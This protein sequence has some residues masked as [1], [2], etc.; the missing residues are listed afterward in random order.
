MT[1]RHCARSPA[2]PLIWPTAVGYG[3]QG[4]G[5]SPSNCPGGAQPAVRTS[6]NPFVERGRARALAEQPGVAALPELRY[7]AER[8]PATQDHVCPVRPALEQRRLRGCHG[9]D[10]DERHRY[11]DESTG[12]G[13][14]G[15]EPGV[16][17]RDQ[18]SC[19]ACVIVGTGPGVG[20]AATSGTDATTFLA[21]RFLDAVAPGQLV[22]APNH[23]A[24]T[25][26][27]QLGTTMNFGAPPP[28]Y[29]VRRTRAGASSRTT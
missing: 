26:P 4:S 18:D 28:A 12:P 6:R 11:L 1:T 13:D 21:T 20:V 15:P 23:Q 8:L 7:R 16:V 29:D 5:F 19:S 2:D 10:P 3:Q 17:G 24:G 9:R 27:A 25:A 14:P 22:S